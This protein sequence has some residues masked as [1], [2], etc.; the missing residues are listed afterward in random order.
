MAVGFCREVPVEA[1]EPCAR[2]IQRWAITHQ[3]G[4]DS[5]PGEVAAV[6]GF[7]PSAADMDALREALRGPNT[8][9]MVG[10]QTRVPI[11]VLDGVIGL[12]QKL[13]LV[14]DG[15]RWAAVLV[16]EVLAAAQW[17]GVI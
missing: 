11:E 9:G 3:M 10:R 6:A 14:G 12:E 15:A 13:G 2:S 5:Q 7:E 17:H 16:P 4:S 8:A 1:L